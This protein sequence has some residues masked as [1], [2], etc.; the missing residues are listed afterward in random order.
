MF[1]LNSL[2]SRYKNEK[3]IYVV[4][5]FIGKGSVFLL[6]EMLGDLL[7]FNS[8]SIVQE[9]IKKF[10][11]DEPLYIS[12]AEMLLIEQNKLDGLI[13]T[14]GYEVVVI[15]NNLFVEYYIVEAT[16]SQLE[17][18]ERDFNKQEDNIIQSIFSF[19]K[20]YDDFAVVA[21]ND[22]NRDCKTI[23]KYKKGEKVK[24]STSIIKTND[25]LTLDS[26]IDDKVAYIYPLIKNER[27]I[28]IYY[29]TREIDNVTIQILSNM[30]QHGCNLIQVVEE[31][32]KE[33]IDEISDFT[34]ILKRININF[35]FRKIPVYRNP[36]LSNEII[37]ISQE[38]IIE[39][40]FENAI[41]AKNGKFYNDI[42]VTA[43]TGSGK[44]IMFQIPAVMLAEKFNLVTIVVSPLIGLMNDQVNNVERL[45]DQA[46][47][48]NSDYTPIEKEIKK[49]QIIDGEKSILYVSPETLLSNSDMSSLIGD[50][51][52]GL[53][54]IDE[55]HTVAT[56]GKSF[57]PDYWFLGDHIRY[58]RRK[59][60]KKGYKSY[61]FPVAT[62]TATATYGGNDDMYYDIINSL[63][64]SIRKPY[65]GEV[66]RNNIIFNI[67]IE[68]KDLDYRSEKENL[69]YKRLNDFL[70]K[71]EKTLSYF[72][73]VRQLRESYNNIKVVKRS[74]VGMYYGG[75]ESTAKNETLLD[76]KTGTKKM[77]LATKAFGM[78]IDIDDIKNVYH[79]A[80]TGNLSD[81]VQEVGRAA[82]KDYIKGIASTD[83][84]K[85][86]FRYINQL[87][88]LSRV[89]DY[90]IIGVINKILDIY[91][92]K[93]KKNFLVAPEEFS[94][95]F[96]EINDD[97]I[98]SKLKTCLLI[99]QKDFEADP[100][101]SN[102]T[103]RFKPRSMFTRG[104]FLIEDSDIEY[105]KSIDWFKYFK[106]YENKESFK[107]IDKKGNGN[108]CVTT[109][110][111]DIYEL[112]F[113]E[114]W[115]DKYR[116]ESFA[117]FKYK[118][119]S[120]TLMGVSL[121][122][123]LK[124]KI[125]LKLESKGTSNFG[126]IMTKY[127]EFMDIFEQVMD[128]FVFKNKHFTIKEFSI[129]LFKNGEGIIANNTQSELITN[130]LL[131]M[132]NN[133]NFKFAFSTGYF[134]K[135]N[136]QTEKYEIL[137]S[138]YKNKVEKINTVLEKNMR[139]YLEDRKCKFLINNNQKGSK[140]K[141]DPILVSA[142][143]L[144]L[145]GLINYDVIAGDSP[146]FFIRVN[147]ENTLARIVSNPNY[148]SKTVE[149]VSQRHYNSIEM[150]QYF[151][152]KL[153]SSKDRWIMIEEYFLGKNLEEIKNK[154]KNNG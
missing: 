143:I 131:N 148:R 97:E 80:P 106:F 90:E 68:S 133:I 43:S 118:F 144:E 111:G 121:D 66:I 63:G 10:T 138:V 23:N 108:E 137:N 112:N 126:T 49:Q 25:Y 140:M 7:K 100:R 51:D 150:M 15:H 57:R 152:E 56:W 99:I 3:T 32:P 2:K 1:D 65:I 22:I 53:M 116:G 75:L 125:L 89:K 11:N 107:R 127:Y 78:G 64:M 4:K 76:F 84:F 72:P 38:V 47:T 35:E 87:F 128:I 114:L 5:D 8:K 123:K 85:E 82:R 27:E 86:D 17:I 12:F 122:K 74:N 145:I 54:I 92:K 45:T 93:R 141:S 73:F 154:I 34:S 104:L 48:I 6:T 109:Y 119:Y 37:K 29:K 103:L 81:Y 146:E 55:A 115:E 39:D 13:D 113:K 149:M 153:S 95:V 21:Y 91:R 130:S 83:Y 88:G 136:S 60:K 50:R 96:R 70:D 110:S 40:I 16:E 58:L 77:V 102:Y 19:F 142:Q 139:K 20:I 59:R 46:V 98:D 44:S 24:F 33:K 94:H 132:L 105:F 52:I 28:F 129:E 120:D 79:F 30:S 69:V 147:N 42:F 62:F 61:A 31:D 14:Y 26:L 124:G 71:G 101:I 9:M 135:Y 41:N 18:Y 151:F 36:I 117:S 67:N 134:L